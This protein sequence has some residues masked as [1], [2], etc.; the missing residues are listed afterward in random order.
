MPS[1]AP[2]V[3]T[4]PRW[5]ARRLYRPRMSST[6]ALALPTVNLDPLVGPLYGS[7][8]VLPPEVARPCAHDPQ[9]GEINGNSAHH[10][11]GQPHDALDLGG[12]EPGADIAT[13]PP[14]HGRHQG[15]RRDDADQQPAH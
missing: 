11:P 9:R 3:S 4:Q 1:N 15:A 12:D 14:Q 5:C 7:P 6:A 13:E 2:M 10:E 8:G